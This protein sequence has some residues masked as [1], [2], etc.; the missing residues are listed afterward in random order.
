MLRQFQNI[1]CMLQGCS[2]RESGRA[3]AVTS[4]DEA[5]KDSHWMIARD[6]SLGIIRFF[7]PTTL[8]S[9]KWSDLT[10]SLDVV[11]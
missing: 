8:G 3:L 11:V 9:C 7:C 2:R 4:V 6:G 5:T 1:Q 10:P